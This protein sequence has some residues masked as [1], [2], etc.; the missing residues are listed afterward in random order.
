MTNTKRKLLAMAMAG[1]V[2]AGV[3]AQKRGDDKR[4]PKPPN[5]VVVAPK[6]EKPPRNNENRGGDKNKGDKRG[7]P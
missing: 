6:G 3:F 1:V 7:R 2:S 5:T 4:P